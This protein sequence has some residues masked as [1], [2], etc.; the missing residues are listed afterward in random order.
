MLDSQWA[1]PQNDYQN[2][3]QELQRTRMAPALLNIMSIVSSIFKNTYENQNL[4]VLI[5]SEF[6]LF[7]K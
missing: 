4:I 6:V 5:S 7:E 2:T 3:A 1:F